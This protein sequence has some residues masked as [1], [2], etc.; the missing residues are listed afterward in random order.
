M[1]ISIVATSILCCPGMAAAESRKLL[2]GTRVTHQDIDAD[3]FAFFDLDLT[4]DAV[5]FLVERSAID[6]YNLIEKDL[7]RCLPDLATC[8]DRECEAVRAA[9]A[10]S[11]LEILGWK[12]I[13]PTMVAILAAGVAIGFA[14]DRAIPQPAT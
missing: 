4:L 11:I 9:P 10:R 6:Y 8:E 7:M 2:K 14:I 5:W 1:L 13:I 3:G 12:V